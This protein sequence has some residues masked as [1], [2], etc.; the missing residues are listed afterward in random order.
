MTLV[1]AAVARSINTAMG[2]KRC[3]N[4]YVEWV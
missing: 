2:G 1:L 3:F 4:K